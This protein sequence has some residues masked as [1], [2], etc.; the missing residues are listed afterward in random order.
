MGRVFSF[1]DVQAGK[2]PEPEYFSAAADITLKWMRSLLQD[3]EIVGGQIFGSVASKTASKRSDFDLIL[4]TTDYTIPD[5]I[6]G[7]KRL[8]EAAFHIPMEPI[9]I[10]SE[11][12]NTTLHSMDSDFLHHMSQVGG[13][14][15]VGEHPASLIKPNNPDIVSVHTSYLASKLRK[16]RDG[17]FL[18]DP[19]R[20]IGTLQ[21]ALEAPISIGR[22]T[23]RTLGIPQ[24][25]DAGEFDDTKKNI[26]RIFRENFGGTSIGDGFDACIAQDMTYSVLLE[27]AIQGDVSQAEYEG[28]ILREGYDQALAQSLAWT[29]DISLF[30]HRTVEGNKSQAE[31]QQSFRERL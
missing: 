22:R 5:N 25:N 23:L 9:L 27:S 17:A 14:N 29:S 8:M 1:V 6:R 16:F 4:V 28:F 19:Q 7:H 3:G 18:T 20:K 11:F 15:V 21:R 31:G 10:P 24:T 30:F 26:A 13:E 12:A 2:I